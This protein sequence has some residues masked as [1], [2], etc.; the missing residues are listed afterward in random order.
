MEIQPQYREDDEAT[1]EEPHRMLA[2][3]RTLNCKIARAEMNVLREL[4]KPQL[5]ESPERSLQ[6]EANRLNSLKRTLKD[7]QAS[8]ERYLKCIQKCNT[9]TVKN[10]LDDDK[11]Y[12]DTNTHLLLLYPH[13]KIIT[14][15]PSKQK[16]CKF[17]F[18]QPFNIDILIWNF[19]YFEI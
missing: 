7:E 6:S 17:V 13:I 1:V 16:V 3:I 15:E 8:C 5:E 2:E 4:R 14:P 10:H 19:V 11:C 18:S 9:E 12:C